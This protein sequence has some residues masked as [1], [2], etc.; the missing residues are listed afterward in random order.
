MEI[1]VSMLIYVRGVVFVHSWV[2]LCLCLFMVCQTMLKTYSPESLAKSMALVMSKTL[3]DEVLI[4]FN[5]A[6]NGA[7]S[8]IDSLKNFK[9]QW[10]ERYFSN[11]L[12]KHE[13]VV[14]TQKILQA[15]NT[16]LSWSLIA[17][18]KYLFIKILIFT[19]QAFAKRNA[20]ALIEVLKY[21]GNKN[22]AR[23]YFISSS[24]KQPQFRVLWQLSPVFGKTIF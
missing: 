7:S 19:W 23:R 8:K 20:F 16:C 4:C 1:C 17:Y 12:T 14:L 18:C 3:P 2:G 24:Y 15:W 21:E 6:L 13:D 11:Y 10:S 9:I 5:T 22:Q